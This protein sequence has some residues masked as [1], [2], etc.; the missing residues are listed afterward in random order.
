MA[1]Y[2]NEIRVMMEKVIHIILEYDRKGFELDTIVGRITLT[3]WML[4]KYI[5]CNEHVNIA[6]LSEVFK[7]DRGLIATHLK[8]LTRMN[9]VQ[10]TKS[11]D[12]K[13]FFMLDLTELGVT[14]YDEMLKKEDRVLDFLYNEI[15]INEE[16]GILKS[17]SKI[18]QLTI[19]KNLKEE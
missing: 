6:K 3:E 19:G 13:R 8:K 9:M 7:M 18:T 2:T 15:T 5:A 11:D 12:D 4:I 16:K 14:L 17:L 10:K 1:N